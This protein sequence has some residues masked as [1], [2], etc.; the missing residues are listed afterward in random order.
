MLKV[1]CGMCI[2]AFCSYIGYFAAEKYRRRKSFFV[3]LSEF[4]ER[5]ISELEFGRRPLSEF[6]GAYEYKGDFAVFIK[7]CLDGKI[8]CGYSFLSAD[9]KNFVN[10]YFS[11]LGK[12]DAHSQSSFFTSVG[13]GVKKYR[14]VSEAD[15]K[16]YGDLYVKLGFLAG[17]AIVVVIV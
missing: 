3:Q 11:M 16:K 4:N 1:I 9:E 2:V 15:A 14:E 8:S 5:F 7:G 6:I 12:G 10:G 17:L 13:A